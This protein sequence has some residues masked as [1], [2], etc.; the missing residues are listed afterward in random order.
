MPAPKKVLSTIPIAASSLVRV[1]RQITVTAPIANS[2]VASAPSE[3]PMRLRL[4]MITNAM[5]IPGSAAC[6]SMSPTSA[7]RRR[8]ANVPIVPAVAPE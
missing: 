1:Q 6:E 7:R 3:S 2:P 5:Q 8:T 4:S